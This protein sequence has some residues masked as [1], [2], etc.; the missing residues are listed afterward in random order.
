MH[1]W[2]DTGPGARRRESV[3]TWAGELLKQKRTRPLEPKGKLDTM[4]GRRGH[5]GVDWQ[6][7]GR[8]GGAVISVAARKV[9]GPEDQPRNAPSQWDKIDWRA[10]RGA[11]TAAAAAD[12]RG[13]TGAGDWP[14]RSAT[15]RS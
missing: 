3:L 15:C 7:L 5:P 8:P 12:L 4:T 1:N 11:G 14:R 2:P 10:Q 9:N 6:Q 13:D